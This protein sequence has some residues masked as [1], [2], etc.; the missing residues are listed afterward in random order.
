MF[1]EKPEASRSPIYNSTWHT[2]IITTIIMR[3]TT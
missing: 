1:R 2:S 3:P